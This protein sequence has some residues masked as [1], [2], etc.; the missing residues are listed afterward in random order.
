M[1][2]FIPS[3]SVA[4]LCALLLPSAFASNWRLDHDENGIKVYTRAIQDSRIREIKGIVTIDASLATVLAVYND[5]TSYPRWNHQCKKAM[6]LEQLSALERYSYQDYNMPF[7]LKDRDLI[8]HSVVSGSKDRVLIKTM[9]AADFCKESALPGCKTIQQ[10]SNI[11]IAL[12]QSEHEFIPLTEGGVRITWT[13]HVE[14]AGSVPKW[15]V[16]SSL[17]DVPYNTLDKL[18]TQVKLE[19]YRE[20]PVDLQKLLK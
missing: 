4:F 10:S 9:A 14:P 1:F 11:M 17:I 13:H 19:K 12:S 15:L 6:L 3:A 7:P 5:F 8:L 20:A 2:K 18:R 16:N